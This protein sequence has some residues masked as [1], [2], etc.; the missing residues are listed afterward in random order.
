MNEC[1]LLSV[2]F[3]LRHPR[4]CRCSRRRSR[5][6]QCRCC[7]WTECCRMNLRLLRDDV[8]PQY[9]AL[10]QELLDVVY[11]RIQLPPVLLMLLPFLLTTI[12][13]PLPWGG[14]GGGLLFLL[15]HTAK[16]R[17][18]PHR[19]KQKRHDFPSRRYLATN[20]FQRLQKKIADTH[21]ERIR[22]GM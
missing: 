8:V 6:C 20:R 14:A 2:P 12:S 15:F 17:R 5:G 3:S 21:S 1:L 16:L 7:S 19:C 22:N 4:G 11:R 10:P 18:I 9:H 13:T